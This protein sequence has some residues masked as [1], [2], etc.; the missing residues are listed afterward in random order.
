[1]V[2]RSIF[3]GPT[4]SQAPLSS[5]R[6]ALQSSLH[7]TQ[8]Q[9]DNV[10]QLFSALTSPTTLSQLAE[11]Y[12]PPSPI[13]P[14][15]SVSDSQRS[16][17][18]PSASLRPF[19]HPT[20]SWRQR[21][22]SLPDSQ[23]PDKRA[24]WNGSYA[25]LAMAGSPTAHLLARKKQNRRSDVT[26]LFQPLAP[27]SSLT[28]SIS[29]PVSPNL[30]SPE[31]RNQLDVLQ[32]EDHFED[33][34]EDKNYFGAAALDMQRKRKSVALETFGLPPPS[35]TPPRSTG[36]GEGGSTSSVH[37]PT[38]SSSSRLTPLHT[39]R[40]P[41]S[42]SGL[43][44]ALQAALSS[45]RY[46]CS[47]LLALRFDED[48]DDTY[49]ENVRSVMALLTSTF[50]DASARL[51]E[52]LD[53]SEKKRVKDE[54]PTPPRG[55]TPTPNG[56]AVGESRRGGSP[57]RHSSVPSAAAIALRSVAEMVSFA[58]MP[59]N[60][61]RFASHVD[62]VSTALNDA[63][64]HIEECIAALRDPQPQ[65]VH[66]ADSPDAPVP[67][68]QDHPA[69]QAYDRLRKELGYA[70]REC[71]R[72]RERLL[73]I[74]APRLPPDAAEDEDMNTPGLRQDSGSES[75]EKGP[76]SPNGPNTGTHD[77][78]G[79]GLSL[80]LGRQDGDEREP[81]VDD[82]T[83]HL[84]LSSSVA[85]LPPA[86]VEQ[87]YEADTGAAGAFARPRS[88]LSREERIAIM[89]ARRTSGM[90]FTAAATGSA[91]PSPLASPISDVG[92][93]DRHGHERERWG[94]GGEVVQELKDVIW[95]VGEK[96]RRMSQLPPQPQPPRTP[97]GEPAQL[98][99]E[100]HTPLEGVRSEDV[101]DEPA[102]AVALG[103]DD[104]SLAYL[105]EADPAE[106][107][108]R[109]D[110]SVDDVFR[111]DLSRRTDLTQE[112]ESS[113]LIAVDGGSP[114][115]EIDD[116]TLELGDS[117]PPASPLPYTRRVL[118]LE[119]A[120]RRHSQPPPAS[121]LHFDE[122]REQDRSVGSS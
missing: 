38:I 95:K 19:S 92:R 106:E 84:L 32:E 26:S 105:E 12:A 93:M 55:N 17:S 101:A 75:S 67:S 64:E 20:G 2:L 58:P 110:D 96:R 27:G 14:G 61:A 54:H 81:D 63:R 4:S 113:I 52:A 91:V 49:W 109:A 45:K 86:G 5:L 68:V 28:A 83:A 97:T 16:P 24:T 85:H 69:F 114:E 79:L 6:V 59:S 100:P 104:V 77:S 23:S 66:Q 120:L 118:E 103:A 74:V 43:H 56:K 99:P 40:H 51:I 88:K 78:T 44:L 53:D 50:S 108:L 33:D 89:K 57:L 10:R 31:P 119:A 1:M 98:P 13:R 48:E 7:T 35:Y 73:E 3:Y 94:P 34:L 107:P 47:Y 121:V 90:L 82:A 9:C 111:I 46:A 8:T 42:L 65:L 18:S 70:L 117:S 112:R 72:G 122:E 102:V 41:L 71:E 25:S 29:A 39:T 116:P 115:N 15:F 11:M 60:M 36:R 30:P 22:T 80:S 37:S 21:T 76:V 62:A 87:V